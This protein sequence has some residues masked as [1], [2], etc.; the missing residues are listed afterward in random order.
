MYLLH[1]DLRA[2]LLQKKKKKKKEKKKKEKKKKFCEIFVRKV[3]QIKFVKHLVQEAICL[4][5]F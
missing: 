2:L 5:F 4:A 3:G 1:S